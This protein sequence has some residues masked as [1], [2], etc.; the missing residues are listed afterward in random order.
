[1]KYLL[2]LLFLTNLLFPQSNY[3]NYLFEEEHSNSFITE[4]KNIG[5]KTFIVGR[6]IDTETNK[7]K[8]K[9]FKLNSEHQIV[10]EKVILHNDST[11]YT[12]DLII[13][14]NLIYLCY[15]TASPSKLPIVD[16]QT[17]ILKMDLDL[18]VLDK[19]A[20]LNRRC[21]WQRANLAI[22]DDF[23]YI[24]GS[25]MQISTCTHAPYIVKL[26][27]ELNKVDSVKPPFPNCEIFNLQVYDN[28][29]IVIGTDRVGDEC[30]FIREFDSNLELKREVIL[31]NKYRDPKDFIIEDNLLYMVSAIDTE[32]NT[33]SS[34][35]RF[36]SGL[37]SKMDLDFNII[38][39]T[40]FGTENADIQNGIA[41]FNDKI[42]TFGSYDVNWQTQDLWNGNITIFNENL[43]EEN[44]FVFKDD[45]ELSDFSDILFT[46]N[47]TILL[48]GWYA[49]DEN[50]NQ[51]GWL[52]ETDFDGNFN[53]NQTVDIDEEF[54]ET[55]SILRN[56][57]NPFNSTTN[58]T[59][60]SKNNDIG[61]IYIYNSNG[62]KIREILNLQIK[63][64]ENSF[65][66]QIEN[67]PSGVYYYQLI[68][69]SGTMAT[70]KMV[71]LK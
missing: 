40:V 22:D 11:I 23:L 18:N 41:K 56:Y 46:T 58:I 48:A 66:L 38:A 37:V 65:K 47:G 16:Y 6:F 1:M 57:P 3:I 14:D 54:P 19:T 28:N 4:A 39:E 59:Y 24:A 60:L 27:I 17:H 12:R 52:F 2:L 29:L 53:P 35:F 26:D 21:K 70:D 71:Y 10:K 13:D 50:T 34:P 55:S 25:F 45:P 62:K 36:Y 30:S 67:I 43:E 33:Y 20:L 69:N 9:I 63:K 32:P 68:L 8:L 49:S 5:D 61:T 64:G 31:D 42:I 7:N 44:S 51:K 15:A